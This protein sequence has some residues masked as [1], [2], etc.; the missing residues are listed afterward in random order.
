MRKIDP[1][2]RAVEKELIQGHPM[3]DRETSAVPLQALNG[4]TKNSMTKRGRFIPKILAPEPDFIFSRTSDASKHLP[5]FTVDPID[6]F[7]HPCSQ[8]AQMSAKLGIVPLF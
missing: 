4:K 3:A 6:L 1:S 7:S 2:C 8:L 5:G